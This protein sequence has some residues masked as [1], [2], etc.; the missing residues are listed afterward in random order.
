[1]W[2]V[3]VAGAGAAGLLAAIRT[4][5]RGRR[6]LLL[7]KNRRAGVKILMSGGT[8]CNL[9]HH[10]D[11][12]GIVRAFGPAGR[13]LYRALKTLDVPSTVAIFEAQ[14]V[15]TKVESSGKIFPVSNRA[16][17]VLDA[18]LQRLKRSGAE[19]VL[20]AP[21]VGLTKEADHFVVRT[22]EASHRARAV[23][24]TTGGLSYPSSGTTGDG[25]ALARQFGH[26]I[27]EP[28]PA[29][30]PIQVAA[31]WVAELRGVRVADAAVRVLALQSAADG[32][33]RTSLLA[34][35]RESL[36]F[37]HFGLTG[38]AVL[39]VS[40]MVARAEPPD[41]DKLLLELDLVPDQPSDVLERQLQLAQAEQG[42]RQ[43]VSLLP[44]QLPQR[45]AVRLCE[46]AGVPT[47]RRA[48]ELSRDQRRQ[49]ID[50]LKHLRLQITGTLGFKKAEVTS[51]G[52]ALDEVDPYTMQSRLCPGLYLAGELLDL[53]G[54][55]GGYNF[56]AAFSTG[57]L[58]GSSV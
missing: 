8:R 31:P 33:G 6:T 50:R 19:L 3:I 42:G 25:Y 20:G 21:L 54:P 36:L 45:L 23:I 29:L 55:I 30:T 38:P 48:A 2:D 16:A 46:L 14:G 22:P 32:A 58:A 12:R 40:R 39:D 28:R 43:V 15:A 56:Q 37:A 24:V 51:G 44:A 9:T 47:G 1:M 17:D 11:T 34:E 57:W 26:A 52:I 18:L 35:R 49:L 27:I 10:T 53:D 7:E 5:E 4:A 13:F 41:R